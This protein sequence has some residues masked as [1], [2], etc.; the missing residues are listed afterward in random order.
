MEKVKNK[1]HSGIGASS[2]SRWMACPGS[3]KLAETAPP[4]P[5]SAYAVEGTVAHEVGELCLKSGK[6]P[7]KY[8]GNVVTKD[9]ISVEIT[10]EMVEAVKVY[11]DTVLMDYKEMMPA[12]MLIENGFDLSE[13]FPGM[14]G[15]N[16][17]II[18]QH[19]G[20]L[21]VYDY[22]HGAGVA[23]EVEE[24]KQ[25]MYYALGA[26]LLGD[27][28]DIE[29]VVVQPRAMHKDG[30]VRRWSTTGKRIYQFAEELKVAAAKT[31]EKNAPLNPGDHC[32]WCPALPFCP[33]VRGKLEETAIAEFS[34][35]L[36]MPTPD[37]MTPAQ[38]QKALN[39]AGAIDEWVRSVQAFAQEQ[40]QR[41]MMIPGYKLVK[42][43]AN[44]AWT[45]EKKVEEAFSIEYGD[46]IFNKKLK[47]PAQMEKLIGKKGKAAVDVFT[48][49]P[50]T[51]S[52]LV[53]ED[54]PRPAVAVDA[55]LD[56]T[57]NSNNLNSL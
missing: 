38:I 49:V 48:E 21:R 45:D 15:T 26:L 25:L 11:I 39:F 14:F 1:L 46:E 27:Y 18:Y 52:V 34:Q 24:N 30:P 33:A 22:K 17:A 13:V 47:S 50:E 29:L 56:F 10:E 54:D 19:F 12:E 57:D 41:G 6:S 8:V 2:A 4:R 3:V 36:A 5:P 28:D 37:L 9:G 44:R 42:K 32:R 53:P 35:P 20:K 40:A 43:R 51:G 16:D 55:Q 23:V 31:Q 7:L